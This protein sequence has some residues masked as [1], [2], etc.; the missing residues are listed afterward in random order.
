MTDFNKFFLGDLKSSPERI[1]GEREGRLNI[2]KNTLSFGVKFLDEAL[3][4]IFPNDFILAGGRSGAG[5]TQLASIIALTSAAKGKRVHYFALEAEAA[6]IERRVKY[7]LLNRE[8]IKSGRDDIARRMNY[9]DWY[10]AKPELDNEVCPFEPKVDAEF[11]AKFQTLFTYYRGSNFTI[12]TFEKLFL[13]VQDQTDLV[14][15]DHLHYFDFDDANEN[16]AQKRIVKKIRDLALFAG[17]P[18]ILIAHLRKSNGNFSP[19]VPDLEDFHGSSDI[20]KMATKSII[21]AP[22]LDQSSPDANSLMTYV[23]TAKCRV[24]GSR[25]RLSAVVCF[26]KALS[27]YQNQFALGHFVD[28]GKKF[29]E[30][31]GEH[32][33]DWVDKRNLV[34][35][36]S[37]NQ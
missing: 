30:V 15:L 18:V 28:G 1:V 3:G 16:A 13:S 26:N 19:L 33:P 27:T 35:L 2:G 29:L 21:V 22:A 14:I 20:F 25:V 4:G 8:I 7:I 31:V 32:I 34:R 37:Q 24:D 11:S 17:K 10:R 36:S 12:D 6:E 5:K 23:R 9:L